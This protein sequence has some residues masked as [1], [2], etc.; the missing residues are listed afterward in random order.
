MT[1]MTTCPAGHVVPSTDVTE[2]GGLKL[3]PVCHPTPADPTRRPWRRIVLAVS[4]AILLVAIGVVVTDLARGSS[5]SNRPGP[6]HAGLP[7]PAAAAPSVPTPHGGNPG[8]SG[9]GSVASSYLAATDDEV[10]FVQWSG[11]DSQLTGTLQLVTSIGTVPNRTTSPDTSTLAATV[12]GATV[13]VRINGNSPEFGTLTKATLILNVPQVDG[14][15]AP[16]TFSRATVS[17]FNAA[18]Q[19][20]EREALAAN[21]SYNQSVATQAANLARACQA[22][23]GSFDTSQPACVILGKTDQ[24]EGASTPNAAFHVPLQA[25]TATITACK[26]AGGTFGPESV[27]SPDV[28]AC[29]ISSLADPLDTQTL[30]Y[31]AP[32]S[33]IPAVAQ[34]RDQCNASGGALNTWTDEPSGDTYYACQTSSGVD[35][36]VL[37]PTPHYDHPL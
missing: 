8:S 28:L 4:V 10:A 13:Q 32:L 17:D 21:D 31:L 1:G 18:V 35:R 27:D 15:F 25:V 36:V 6:T 9:V 3:C 14:T 7:G 2:V 16:A 12:T 5:S 29:T 30:Q 33:D 11:A 26:A 34:L 22:A 24:V 20:L 19:A 23:G 37:G